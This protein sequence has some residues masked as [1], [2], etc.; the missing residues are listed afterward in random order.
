MAAKKTRPVPTTPEERTAEHKRQML[1]QVWLP[2]GGGIVLV[3]AVCVL[4][5]L[6]TVYRS[7]EIN[8]WGNISSIYLLIPTLLVNLVPLILLG[9]AIYGMSKLLA[10][11]P[12]WMYAVQAFFGRIYAFTRQAADKLAA[13]VL[14]AGGFS[15]GLK[16]ARRKIT[17]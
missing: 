7:T 10:K 15:E 3:L 9:L 14:A 16:A 17:R 4:A 5:I 12:G 6:G 11:M 8:R 2:L 13:P 1:L